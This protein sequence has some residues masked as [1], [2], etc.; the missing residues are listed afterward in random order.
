MESRR[1]GKWLL[2]LGTAQICNESVHDQRS[3]FLSAVDIESKRR[4]KEDLHPLEDL[5]PFLDATGNIVTK[6]EVL[7]AFLNS[8]TSCFPGTQ[9]PEWEDRDW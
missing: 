8:T 5:H 7:D 6:D 2:H 9:S 4:A 3:C 1:Y